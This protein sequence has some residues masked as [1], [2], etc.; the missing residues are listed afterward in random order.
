[1]QL[2]HHVCSRRH[3]LDD[4]VGEVTRVRRGEAHALQARDRA[5]GS[6]QLAERQ[7]VAELHA[8][9]ID[10]LTQQGDL[11]DSLLHQ[12]L[13]LREDLT[14]ATILLGAAQRGHNAE[15]AGVVASD[16]DRDPRRIRRF[17]PGRQVRGKLHQRLGD[18]HL[19]LLL[20]AST[21]KQD[22]QRAE[23]V[24]AEHHI[25]PRGLADDLALVL[26]RQAPSYRDLHAR[27]L[28]LHRHQVRQISVQLVVGVLAHGTGIE[29]Q[30]IRIRACRGPD[31]T[32]TLEQPRQALGVVHIHLA[33]I[34][35]HLIGA[36]GVQRRG[37]HEGS[38]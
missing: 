38:S 20:D 32:G 5:A 15:S 6:Q 22:R 4:I 24:R 7:L 33:A 13:H 26:L 19:R 31:I 27:V 30:H 10:I 29:D 34:G 35:A 12:R 18:L 28:L 9:G 37:G 25:H 8:I 21:L 3:R 11:D 1:M 36:H 16:A 14:G 23:V 17:P 2:R